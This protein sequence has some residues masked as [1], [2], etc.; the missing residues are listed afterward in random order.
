MRGGGVFKPVITSLGD[1]EKLY[2]PKKN[3]GLLEDI[4]NDNNLELVWEKETNIDWSKVPFDTKVLCKF[5]DFWHKRYF[6]GVNN[7]GKP[8]AFYD[9]QNSWSA[10]GC[11]LISSISGFV[12]F[13]GNEHL[14]KGGK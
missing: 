1:E 7:E 11:E 6:A 12:L 8:L 10:N 14:L 2:K 4:L 13:E 9:G 3:T 5:G